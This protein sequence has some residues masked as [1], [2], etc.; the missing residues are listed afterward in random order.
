MRH[1]H[2]P[3]ANDENGQSVDRL[4]VLRELLAWTVLIL[5]LAGFFYLQIQVQNDVPGLTGTFLLLLLVLIEVVV[6]IRVSS[7]I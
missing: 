3:N 4:G 1:V 7:I 6:L 2:I 5:T